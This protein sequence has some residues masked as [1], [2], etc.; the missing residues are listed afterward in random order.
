MA[1]I[2]ACPEPAQTSTPHA[3]AEPAPRAD[4]TSAAGRSS[5]P[6]QPQTG[7]STPPASAPSASTSPT[8]ASTP[9]EFHSLTRR[10]NR[11]WISHADTDQLRDLAFWL[12]AHSPDV[13]AV[14]LADL[15]T[16]DES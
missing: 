10:Q 12:N 15:A 13:V 7:A 11:Q 1:T 14:A 5:S 9:N 2:D 4:T 6:A 16:V 3:S 8:T